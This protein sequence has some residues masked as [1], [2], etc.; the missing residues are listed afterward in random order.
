MRERC[1]ARRR[2][3][4]QS[5]E[6]SIQVSTNVATYTPQDTANLLA[7][8]RSTGK[9][10]AAL[11]PYSLYLEPFSPPPPV[12]LPLQVRLCCYQG[13]WMLPGVPVCIG[14]HSSLW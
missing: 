6:P 3:L 10:A 2:A 9:L 1:L 13:I 14:H 7:S 5:T 11:L 4:L 8:Y 12:S